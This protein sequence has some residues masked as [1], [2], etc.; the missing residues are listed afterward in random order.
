MTDSRITV[1]SALAVHPARGNSVNSV[2]KTGL[3]FKRHNLPPERHGVIF[4]RTSS[5][6]MSSK[7]YR[8]IIGGVLLLA[9]AIAV[10]GFVF[11]SSAKS[12]EEKGTRE[13]YEDENASNGSALD[14]LAITPVAGPWGLRN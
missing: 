5:I 3:N 1:D 13:R 12:P 4:D 9:V 11:G 14:Y 6:P 10:G 2:T 7:A 8:S